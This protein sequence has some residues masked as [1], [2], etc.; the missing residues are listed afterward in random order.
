MFE[1]NDFRIWIKSTS[2]KKQNHSS[3]QVF[4]LSLASFNVHGRTHSS[5][6]TWFP[7]EL[8]CYWAKLYRHEEVFPSFQ[9]TQDF[10]LTLDCHYLLV[11][12]PV[13]VL[14]L[15]Q[16]IGLTQVIIYFWQLY[17]NQRSTNFVTKMDFP[18]IKIL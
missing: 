1:L 13:C 8:C 3:L 4:S 15:Y 5:Q 11:L 14:S 9:W 10:S 12:R 7:L 17:S 18:C 6:S 16:L 2:A